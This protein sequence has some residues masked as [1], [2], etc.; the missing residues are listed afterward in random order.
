MGDSSSSSP[1]NSGS[2]ASWAT[3]WDRWG[4]VSWHWAQPCCSTPLSSSSA[5]ASSSQGLCLWSDLSAHDSTTTSSVTTCTTVVPSPGQALS[6]S[7][8][9]C[10]PSSSPRCPLSTGCTSGCPGSR[11]SS[12][13]QTRS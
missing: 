13:A 12:R 5:I 4:Y 6:S 9:D 1:S 8:Q 7:S 3:T 10:L 2:S 11:R